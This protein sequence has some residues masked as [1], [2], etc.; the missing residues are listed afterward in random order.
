M[1]QL[2][3]IYRYISKKF[4]TIHLDYPVYQTH[5]YGHGKP[6]H[7]MLY[8]IIN[9]NRTIYN[10]LLN[11]TLDYKDSFHEIKD[12]NLETD[13][14]KPVFNNAFIPALDLFGIYSMIAYYR[15]TS[16]IEVGSGN[17]TKIAYK[18]IK[19]NNLNTNIISIDPQPREIMYPSAQPH[20]DR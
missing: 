7:P 19:E 8:S 9:N 18:A 4:Q 20:L 15:P 17:S 13:P 12:K 14:L 3:P 10:E 1:L 6:A 16:Y 5:R 11:N 2:K